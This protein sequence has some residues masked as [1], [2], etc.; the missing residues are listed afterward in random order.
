MWC[1]TPTFDLGKL[2]TLPFDLG[3]LV[4]LT[5]DLGKLVFKDILTNFVDQA[6]YH[7]MNMINM[8]M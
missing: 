8:Y 1:V 4:T 6:C 3:K 2:V 5:F 7:R